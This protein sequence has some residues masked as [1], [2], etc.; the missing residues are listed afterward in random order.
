MASS[1]FLKTTGLFIGMVGSTLLFSP[2]VLAMTPFSASY[3]FSYNG[4]TVGSATR[5][6]TQS[7]NQW[8][9]SFRATAIGMASASEVSQFSVHNGKITSQNFSRTSKILV[10]S[11]SMSIK[12]NPASKLINTQKDDK[13]RSFAWKAGVLDELNA[14]LQLREDLKKSALEPQYLIADAKEIEGRRFVRSGQETIKTPYGSFE[15]LKVVLKHS[16]PNR[17][18]TFWLAKNLDYLPVKVSHQ[19]AKTSYSLLLKGYQ[20]AA[21]K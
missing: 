17:A 7:G 9:Y 20:G 10:H 5:V 11:N 12:F 16:K 8:K 1:A 19:D 2:S 3:D 4:K 13:K 21:N 6:L 15:T 18:T 14:E